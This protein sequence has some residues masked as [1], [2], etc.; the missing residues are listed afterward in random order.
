MD[1]LISDIPVIG[2]YVDVCILCTG[3][4]D[5]QGMGSSSSSS[6][7][8]VSKVKTNETPSSAA[9]FVA[10]GMKGS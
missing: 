3:I 4:R 2:A 1:N 8:L 7:C 5:L 10:S 6:A 9:Q